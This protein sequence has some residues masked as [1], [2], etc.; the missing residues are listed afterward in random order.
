MPITEDAGPVPSEFVIEGAF[1]GD[2]Q[3]EGGCAWV[4]AQGRRYQIEYLTGHQVSFDP[5]QLLTAEGEVFAEEGDRLRLRGALAEAVM[6][7]CQVGP[8]FQANS[9]QRL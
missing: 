8:V 6:T 3:L 4:A 5:L 7:T 1:G 9:V 2:A